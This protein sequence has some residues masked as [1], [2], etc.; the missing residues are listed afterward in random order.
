MSPDE[1]GPIIF[2]SL[3]ILDMNIWMTRFFYSSDKMKLKFKSYVP[4]GEKLI[5]VFY[6]LGR[7][8]SNGE[9]NPG[10]VFNSDLNLSLLWSLSLKLGF[11]CKTQKDLTA[12]Q[13]FLLCVTPRADACFCIKH[14]RQ[15]RCF[16]V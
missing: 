10:V 15:V 8:S 12:E 14:A 13:Y 1:M 16:P 9:R 6:F 5:S 3:C 7:T 4:R 2:L 11:F